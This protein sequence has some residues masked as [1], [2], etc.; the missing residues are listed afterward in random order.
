MK[1]QYEWGGRR[2]EL[3]IESLGDHRYR[4]RQGEET[5]EL[6]ARPLADGG[7]LIQRGVKTVRVYAHAEG[8][9]RQIWLAGR[10]YRLR[11]VERRRVEGALTG[12]E[13]GSLRAEMPCQ[14]VKILVAAGE[15]VAEGEPLLLMEAMKMELRLAAP[16]AGRVGEWF[17]VEG[18]VV[19]RGGE[20]LRF[21]AAEA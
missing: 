21:E 4:L 5:Q 18:Q 12:G 2:C 8:D 14:I 13:H 3:D 10:C 9:E 16:V 1:R 7:W 6:S 19:P 17:V 20:L 15:E 11:Q